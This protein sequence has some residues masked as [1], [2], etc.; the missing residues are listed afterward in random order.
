MQKNSKIIP[1]KD[2]QI[3]HPGDAVVGE[4]RWKNLVF[5]RYLHPK[6]ADIAP[7][8]ATNDHIL[9]FGDS[10]AVKGE[11]SLNDGPWKPFVWHTPQWFIGQAF[12]N[13]R[14]SRWRTI[15]NEDIDLAV[16]YI[17]LSPQLL[18]EH[19]LQ[20]ADRVPPTIELVS[21]IGMI[22]PLMQQLGLAL[23]AEAVKDHPYE[24]IYVE[25]IASLLSIHL[26]RNYCVFSYTV[27]EYAGKPRRLKLVLEYV[28]NHLGED[29]S[30]EHLAS[31][32]NM[33]MYH[34]A[35]T[36]KE[37]VGIPPHKYIT[38]SRIEKAKDLLKQSDKSI[39]EIALDLGY[40]INHFTQV[41]KRTAGCSPSQFRQENK[42]R[43]KHFTQP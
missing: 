21:G 30:L 9:A 40:R 26:L 32:A 8:P 14:N 1:G 33:S 13:R 18:A 28:H 39:S 41:F 42:V 34:F 29:L 22:D 16:C 36:F 10:G 20:A 12:Q 27:P 6:K 17:H 15:C 11:H 31:L 38:Q 5:T 43:K 23:K 19:A 3:Y 24:K 25:T 35:R 37:S 4:D 2:Y 7:R